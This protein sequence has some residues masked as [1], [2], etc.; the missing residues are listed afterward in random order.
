MVPGV[1]RFLCKSPLVRLF[2]ASSLL[3]ALLLLSSG[4]Q[5]SMHGW[6]QSHGGVLRDE[7]QHRVD[8]AVQRLGSHGSGIRLEVSVLASNSVAAY[9][10][11][12]GRG[13]V[14]RGLV[15]LLG[16]EELTAAI[17]HELGH[18]LNDGHVHAVAGLRGCETSADAE[19]RAD[20][21]GAALM[22]ARGLPPVAMM[23]MLQKVKSVDPPLS[24][25]R[26]LSRRI[27]LLQARFSDSTRRQHRS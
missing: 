11:P 15:D 2:A 12:D 19:A 21:A 23:R 17:A 26:E 24:C 13:F 3:I 14:T 16:D 25:Q 20:A 27:R 5:Q 6:I 9:C 8:Q 4:C 18:L 1:A 22:Q 10:W 7:R